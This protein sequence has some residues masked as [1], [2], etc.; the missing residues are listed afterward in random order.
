MVEFLTGVEILW[1]SLAVPIVV[2]LVTWRTRM[3]S[4]E[5]SVGL[6]AAMWTVW[7]GSYFLVRWGPEWLTEGHTFIFTTMALALLG[8]LLGFISV[9][10]NMRTWVHRLLYAM[11]GVLTLLL[12]PGALFSAFHF[13]VAPIVA[14]TFVT[15]AVITKRD[16]GTVQRLEDVPHPANG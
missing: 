10:V 7:W 16:E 14:V 4:G 12:I 2:A 9:V 13:N 15:L 5:R 8:G 6:A 11:A 1:T 3:L